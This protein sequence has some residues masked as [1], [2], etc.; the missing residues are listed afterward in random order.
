MIH[1]SIYWVRYT[2]RLLASREVT[3]CCKVGKNKR[4]QEEKR[5]PLNT[6]KNYKNQLKMEPGR[7]KM[8]PG[9]TTSG[10]KIEKN[11]LNRPKWLPD[12]SQ[13]PFTGNEP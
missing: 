7:P 9:C 13:D 5:C 3:W 1:L 2:L 12:V 8:K 6:K 11:A 10:A 4:D